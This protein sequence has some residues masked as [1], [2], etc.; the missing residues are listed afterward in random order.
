MYKIKRVSHCNTFAKEKKIYKEICLFYFISPYI[1][2]LHELAPKIKTKY[3]KPGWVSWKRCL[4]FPFKVFLWIWQTSFRTNLKKQIQYT[5]HNDQILISIIISFILYPKHCF[6][7]NGFH[8]FLK[9]LKLFIRFWYL[10]FVNL[11]C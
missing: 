1:Y 3:I 5:N 7:W 11:C 2:V 4:I 10:Y 9:T 6:L 8:P